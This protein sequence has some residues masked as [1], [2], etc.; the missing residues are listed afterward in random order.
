ME[1]LREIG[2]EGPCAAEMI[3]GYQ[4]AGDHIILSTKN[5]M[6]RIFEM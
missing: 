5:A 1:A 4:Q 2:Y 3:P 6:D